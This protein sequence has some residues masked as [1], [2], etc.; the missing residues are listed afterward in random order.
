MRLGKGLSVVLC[1]MLLLSVSAFSVLANGSDSRELH[2]AVVAEAL[3]SPVQVPADSPV[4]VTELPQ[5][6]KHWV[7]DELAEFKQRIVAIAGT[8]S[9]YDGISEHDKSIIRN[10]ILNEEYLDQPIKAEYWAVLLNAVLKLPAD[11][12]ERLLDMY[13]HDLAT[14]DEIA[15]EDAVGGMVKLLSLQYLRGYSTAEEL[16]PAK[17]LKDLQAVSDRQN[18]LVRTAYSAGLVDS[19]TVEYFR[20]KERLTVAEAISMVYRVVTKYNVTY[21]STGERD[22]QEPAVPVRVGW[23]DAELQRYRERLQRKLVALKTAES[24]L[25][26]GRVGNDER[27][28]AAVSVEQ[29]SEV[30]RSTLGISDQKVVHS[31]TFGLVQGDTVPR[32]VAVAGLVKLLHY[33]GM[34]RGRDAS[35]RERLAA[36]V[37]FGDYSQAFDTSKLAIAYSEG[38]VRGY[39]DHTFRPKQA[40]TKGEALILMLSVIERCM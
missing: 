25:T 18:A 11:S 37:A 10:Y 7:Y 21:S 39:P 36:A 34:V 22:K 12:K 40:L 3:S 27:L 23:V 24:I 35:E 14:G 16:E 28:N 26:D 6:E 31:Y 1:T 8:D 13:V 30:L 2:V 9:Q 33:T 17:A 5:K 20:P 29:W 38:L 19:R 4:V 15:R 32:D